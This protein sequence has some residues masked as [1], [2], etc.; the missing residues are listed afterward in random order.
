MQVQ[1]AKWGNSLGLRIPKE[2]AAKVGLAEGSRVDL[3]AEGSTIVISID[4]PVYSLADLLEVE[5]AESL[6]D[7]WGWGPDL[8]REAME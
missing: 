3:R 2:V 6:K 4:R 7:A 5:G 1:V 8:G